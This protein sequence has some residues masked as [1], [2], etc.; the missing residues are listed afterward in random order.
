MYTIESLLSERPQSLTAREV[1]QI[2]N[3]SVKEVARLC[4]NGQLPS[5]KEAGRW[6]VDRDE[7]A[8]LLMSRRR[9]AT[10]SPAD[11]SRE[12][13]SA[14]TRLLAPALRPLL[15]IWGKGL[16]GS[17]YDLP[18]PF[19]DPRTHASGVDSDRILLFGTADAVG[20]GV[21]SHD[22]ALPGMLARSLSAQTGRG[23]DVDVIASPDARA[24]TA[25]AELM[26][27]NLW[28][29]DAVVLTLGLNEAV[30]LEPIQ[31]WIH[32]LGCAL[33]FISGRGMP[34]VRIYVL[35]THS[36][37]P[38]SRYDTLIEPITSRHTTALNLATASLCHSRTNVTV[39]PV[40]DA[41]ATPGLPARV[42]AGY[43]QVARL[44]A[45]QMIA[46]VNEHFTIYGSLQSRNAR[47]AT[48][49]E[50][51]RQKALSALNL[52]ESLP[53]QRFDSIVDLARRAFGTKS[54]AL[55]VVESDRAWAKSL[56]GSTLQNA[57]R[58]VSLC[59]TAISVAGALVVHDVSTDARFDYPRLREPLEPIRFYA[60]FPVEAPNGER[61]GAL[62]VFDP[63]TRNTTDV[64]QSLLRDFALMAQAELWLQQVS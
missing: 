64:D 21:V 7:L 8:T 12:V 19:D 41:S 33:D 22:L 18:R 20:W 61:I 31:K 34:N 17:R 39:V 57:P 9:A 16:A 10:P 60:A 49:S 52:V 58:D 3:C 48:A 14:R 13:Q 32:H 62:C 11:V 43:R 6:T 38:A 37:G 1:A 30:Q 26:N 42:R 27:V 2:L 25:I 23:T 36:T 28:R 51:E 56:A 15:Q 53:D 24:S 46:G 5:T 55:A 35:G 47:A 45:S 29:Y 40:D 54:A 63:C 4:R 44:L 50:S 59:T